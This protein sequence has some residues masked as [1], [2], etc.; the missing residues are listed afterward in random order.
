VARQR[1]LEEALAAAERRAE[2]LALE[3]GHLQ[4]HLAA[5]VAL[6][7]PPL[8]R[9]ESIDE[10]HLDARLATTGTALWEGARRVTELV[11]ERRELIE[12]CARAEAAATSARDACTRLAS[13]LAESLGLDGQGRAVVARTP[14]RTPHSAVLAGSSRERGSR[15]GR[16]TCTP[17]VGG[18]GLSREELVARGRS[19]FNEYLRNSR[20]TPATGARVSSSSRPR[21]EKVQ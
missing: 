10:H 5:A 4:A 3:N 18:A 21:S 20:G 15:S 17:R 2:G 8:K 11:A 12:R 14:M 7:P 6:A 1:Q 9:D 19:C 13:R 16:D